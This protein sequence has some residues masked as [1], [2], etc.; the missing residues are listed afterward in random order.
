MRHPV[1]VAREAA[2]LDLLS[3]G[4]FEL[5]LGA[6]RPTASADYRAIGRAQEAGG[7]RV[8]RLIESIGIIN[9]LLNGQSLTTSGKHYTVDGATPFPERSGS[10]PPLL[11]AGSGKRLLG[12]AAR[13]ADIV[14]IG[15]PPDSGEDEVKERV[16][17]VREAAGERFDALELNLNLVA[18]GEG[19]SPW[20]AR[21]GLDPAELMRKRSPLVLQGSTDQMAE[22]L[23]RMHEVLGVSFVNA[24]ATSLDVMAPVVARLAA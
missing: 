16:G 22:Q 3:G 14:A 18:V 17:W 7:V 9:A 1:L 2:T 6:G 12:A 13:E 5:G 8:E 11:V 23:I 19:S 24:P 10:R 15:A 20:L 21:L 4:R